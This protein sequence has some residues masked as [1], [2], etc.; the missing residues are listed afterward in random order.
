MADFYIAFEPMIRHEGYPGYVNNPS[1]HGGETVAGISR[2]NWPGSKVWSIVDAAKNRPNFPANLK[3]DKDLRP[4][5]QTFYLANFWT[6]FMS[7][8]NSQ[9]L[10]TWLFDK[11]V[12]CGIRQAMKFLQR[13]VGVKDDGLPGPQTLN[14]ANNYIDPAQ[15]VELCRDKARQFY[16][17]LADN[18]PSQKQFL[19]GWL[20]RC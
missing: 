6:Q 20:A 2:K 1:D 13:A 4:A 7:D 16:R 15:L 10:A 19:A 14:A 5:V 18:D 12:N 11:G 8:L 17:Q 9:E 3:D